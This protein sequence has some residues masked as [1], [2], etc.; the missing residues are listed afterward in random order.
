MQVK[1]K[2]LFLGFTLIC[3]LSYAQG[4]WELMEVPVDQHLRSVFFTDSLYGWAVG[5]TGTIIHTMDGGESWTIQDAGTTNNIVNVFFLNRNLGWASSWNFNGFYGTLL[6]QTTDGGS[7]W[8]QEAYPDDHLFMNCILYLD[9]LTGW[10]GGSPH[11]LVKTTDGGKSWTQAA[12]DTNALAFFP[13]LNIFF[14]D[15]NHAYACGGMFDIAGVIWSTSNGGDLWYPISTDDA[16]ADEVHGLHIFDPVTVLGSGGDPDQGYG[17][18]MIR[19]A[20]GGVNWDYEELSM[21][22]NAFDLD[23]RNSTEA[24]APLGPRQKLIYSLDAGENWEQIDSP[25]NTSIFDMIFPD[26]LHGYAVGYNGAFI[27]YQPKGVGI[28]EINK[29]DLEIS[30][31]PNP[32]ENQVSVQFNI[33]PVNGEQWRIGE[34]GIFDGTGKLMDMIFINDLLIGANFVDVDVS[35]FLPGIYICRLQLKGRDKHLILTQKLIL[36]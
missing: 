20:N 1:K 27:K 30:L 3:S 11:A 12:I 22:G 33:R 28:D 2:I 10:M 6:L 36:E 9:S 13:V 26:T 31:F 8:T 19:T 34:L 35:G 23:F 21:P 29:E 16:P 25:G 4:S 24:W 15:E 5:D 14:Y 17:V 18:A 7:T 32:A